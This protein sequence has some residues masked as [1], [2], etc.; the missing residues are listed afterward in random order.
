[1]HVRPSS[2]TPLRYSWRQAHPAGAFY[3][4]DLVNQRGL[5]DIARRLD[6]GGLPGAEEL[7]RLDEAGA[8][9]P[10]AFAPSSYP[11]HG[12]FRDVEEAALVYRDEV[13]FAPWDTYKWSES[14]VGLS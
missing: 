3:Q 11:G 9:R 14:S 8:L 13:E 1:M 7:E 10:I 4:L 12:V 6:G 5:G 2:F